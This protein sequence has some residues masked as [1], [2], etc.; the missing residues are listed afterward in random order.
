MGTELVVPTTG[1]MISLE[2]PEQ[3]ARVLYEIRELE[4]QVKVLKAA[5]RDSIVEHSRLQG[6]KTIHFQGMSATVGTT[7]SITWDYEV[8]TELLAAGLPEERFNELVMTEISYK[9]NA[10]V[11]NSIAKSNEVYGEIIERAKTREEK[12]ASVTIKTTK[13]G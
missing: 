1:E 4:Y 5:L 2:D 10:S 3:C 6:T 7:T 13:G 9:V 8:L 12:K 11:A